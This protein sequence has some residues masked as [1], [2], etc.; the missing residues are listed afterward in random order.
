MTLRSGLNA[1][2]RKWDPILPW[3]IFLATIGGTL[4][5]LQ[6]LIVRLLK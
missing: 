3:A 5:I 4:G 2:L 6:V 1:R